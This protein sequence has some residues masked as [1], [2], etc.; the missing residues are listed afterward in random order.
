MKK[1]LKNL[2][3]IAFLAISLGVSAQKLSVNV[4][5][6]NSTTTTKHSIISLV[7]SANGFTLGADYDV[8]VADNMGV[9]VGLN[10]S[11]TFSN[12]EPILYVRMKG[13]YHALNLPIRFFY[14]YAIND[15]LKVFGLLGPKLTF[16]V[17][18]TLTDGRQ[19]VNLY[20]AE[21]SYS[22]FNLLI[23]P[24][25][26]AKYKTF[27]AKAGYD[28]GLLNRYSNS[29]TDLLNTKIT[30]TTNQFYISLGYCF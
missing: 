19:S 27:V 21:S 3:V 29:S 26:G 30:M 9:N 28:F 5:Y 24:G 1:S 18:A 13:N 8:M 10:Y 11:L 6:L 15:D 12:L 23:G 4:G 22:R 7:E 25:I 14:E 17:A 16:D 20:E 2:V